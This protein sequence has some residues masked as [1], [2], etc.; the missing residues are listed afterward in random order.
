[1]PARAHALAQPN[2]K[3]RNSLS[4]F[5]KEELNHNLDNS[6]AVKTGHKNYNTCKPIFG[7]KDASN[8]SGMVKTV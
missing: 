3:V 2:G 6:D 5:V 1:M 8:N 7:T 4:T